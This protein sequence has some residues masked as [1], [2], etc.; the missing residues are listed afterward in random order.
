VAARIPGRARPRAQSSSLPEIEKEAGRSTSLALRWPPVGDGDIQPIP[1]A[2][3]DFSSR[4][5]RAA[6]KR[7][8]TSVA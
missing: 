6:A 8:I 3:A 4:R 5:S 2:V 7:K 1:E